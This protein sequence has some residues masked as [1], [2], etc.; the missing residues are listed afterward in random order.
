MR[1]NKITVVI[2]KPIDEV[3][4]FTTNPQNTHLWIPSISEEITDEYPPKI[5]TRYRNRGESDNWDEY[6]VVDFN[7]NE[8]FILSDLDEN[9]FVKYTYRKLD[10]NKTEME[11]FEWM[12]NGELNKPFT[13]SILGNL[14]KVMEG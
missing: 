6:K 8:V 9:Y 3:F 5:N 13:E 14:K 12:T 7:Q 4:E 1:E 2:N 11:Y 10:E